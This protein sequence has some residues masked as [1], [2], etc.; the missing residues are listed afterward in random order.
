MNLGYDGDLYMLAFEHRG[1]FP[2]QLFGITG[3]PTRERAARISDTK[4]L[5]FEGFANYLRAIDAY[6]GS[7]A[8]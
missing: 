6:R 4:T 5:I 8:S 2:K 7:Q 1:S 3:V